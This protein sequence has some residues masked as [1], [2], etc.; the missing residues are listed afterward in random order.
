MYYHSCPPQPRSTSDF[1]SGDV[2]GGDFVCVCG[3]FELTKF[4]KLSQS[5]LGLAFFVVFK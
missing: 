1:S 5:F 2:P 3:L 4:V